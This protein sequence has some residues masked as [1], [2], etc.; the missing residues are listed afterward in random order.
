MPLPDASASIGDAGAD[1]GHS[2]GLDDD[3]ERQAA[4][5]V[6]AGE[7]DAAAALDRPARGVH[8]GGV[9]RLDAG[10][11]ERLD[12]AVAIDVEDGGQRDPRHPEQLGGEARAHLSRADQ[13]DAQRRAGLVEPLLQP[14][15]VAHGSGSL[16]DGAGRVMRKGSPSR[17]RGRSPTRTHTSPGSLG[18]VRPSALRSR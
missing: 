13:A 4:E 8:V 9:R 12:R 6:D 3:V 10:L 16:F 11:A 1:V 7:G 18:S 14:V 2:G 5:L 17:S 15:S